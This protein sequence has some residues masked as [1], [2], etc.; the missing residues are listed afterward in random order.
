M[1]NIH[2]M[3]DYQNNP[4]NYVNRQQAPP[5]L[6]NESRQAIGMFGILTGQAG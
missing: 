5:V 1:S 3:S 6:D 2:G 4:N